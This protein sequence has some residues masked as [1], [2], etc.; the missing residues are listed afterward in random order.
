MATF[1]ER[2]RILAIWDHWKDKPWPKGATNFTVLDELPGEG[3]LPPVNLTDPIPDAVIKTRTFCCFMKH[4]PGQGGFHLVIMCEGVVCRD[5]YVEPRD[6][7]P[8]DR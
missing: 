6:T 7:A 1:D 3:A 8:I 2:E 5:D 4:I